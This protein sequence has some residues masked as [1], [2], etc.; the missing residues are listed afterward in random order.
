MILYGSV[1]IFC[2]GGILMHPGRESEKG[3][4]NPVVKIGNINRRIETRPG[5]AWLNSAEPLPTFVP[6]RGDPSMTG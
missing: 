2:L 4:K 3:R 1:K 5:S 6:A